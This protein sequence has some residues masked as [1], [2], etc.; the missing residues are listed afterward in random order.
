MSRLVNPVAVRPDELRHG[1]VLVVTVA[2]H[3]M[4]RGDE[5]IFRVYRCD[6]PPQVADGIPQGSRVSVIHEKV[7]ADAL[8]PVVDWAGAMPD[9]YA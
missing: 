7:V 8:F 3:V 6:Y 5:R 1:D 9:P 4:E 2:L